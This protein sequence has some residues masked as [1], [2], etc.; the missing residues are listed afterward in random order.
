MCVFLT[1]DTREKDLLN[2]LN[3]AIISGVEVRGKL[4][5]IR[6]DS[7]AVFWIHHILISTIKASWITLGNQTLEYI[8]TGFWSGSIDQQDQL[9]RH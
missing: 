9:V 8:H 1:A 4:V 7:L 3:E 2:M 6:L 5:G